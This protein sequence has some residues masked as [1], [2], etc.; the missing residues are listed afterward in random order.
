ML[1][2][3]RRDYAKTVYKYCFYS[4]EINN[5]EIIILSHTLIH[6]DISMQIVMSGFSMLFFSFSQRL[7]IKLAY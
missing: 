6:F 7:H 1:R 3:E 2:N 4:S 5:P